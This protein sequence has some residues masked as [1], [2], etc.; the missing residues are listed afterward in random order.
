MGETGYYR[1]ATLFCKRE[2]ARG[3]FGK[4]VYAEAQYNHD[5][6]NMEQSF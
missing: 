4:F 3:S 6:R 5:I 1:P 2:L